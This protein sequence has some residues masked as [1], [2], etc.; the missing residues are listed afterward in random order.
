MVVREPI[1]ELEALQ[2]KSAILFTD[3]LNAIAI[4]EFNKSDDTLLPLELGE[5]YS[6]TM[7]YADMLGRRRI[8]LQ[9]DN[10]LSKHNYN[11]DAIY[12]YADIPQV[13]R[14]SSFAEAIDDLLSRYPQLKDNYEDVRRAYSTDKTFALAKSTSI[15]VTRK[16]RD[17]MVKALREGKP[18][19][20]AAEMISRVGNF[21]RSYSELIYRTNLSTSYTAGLFKQV[22]APEVREVTPAFRFDAILDSSVRPNHRAADG[23]VASIDDDAW[24]I[25][26][27]PLGY[28]C[29]C[30]LTLVDKFT[31]Q[32][33]GLLTKD[34]TLYKSPRPPDAYPDIGFKFFAQRVDKRIYG[35]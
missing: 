6:K 11:A 19:D 17:I 33:K 22:E 4:A 24:D 1:D 15:E 5:L 32:R 29:R 16:V 10:L 20:N 25:I 14:V 13:P 12:I 8:I 7:I 2:N 26:S 9:L 27:P 3:I 28:R 31:L 21:T 23:F 35:R 18:V 30:S 34:G